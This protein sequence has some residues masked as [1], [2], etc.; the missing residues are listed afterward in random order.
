MG[1][2]DGSRTDAESRRAPTSRNRSCEVVTSHLPRLLRLGRPN[3]LQSCWRG[4]E[5]SKAGG[6]QAYPPHPSTGAEASPVERCLPTC[7][8]HETTPCRLPAQ[9]QLLVRPQSNEPASN[10]VRDAGL[11][12]CGLLHPSRPARFSRY[13]R[14]LQVDLHRG[15][16][17]PL[18]GR[19]RGRQARPRPR[20]F[21]PHGS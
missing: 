15:A 8:A 1:R 6:L 18:R 7:S 9:Q 12:A 13:W 14:C 20:R 3:G 4:P 11:R 19:P 5:G 16:R 2:C 17:C 21:Q 10:S